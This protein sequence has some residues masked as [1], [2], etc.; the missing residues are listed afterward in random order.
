LRITHLTTYDSTGGAAR[1][2]YRLHSGL[3]IIGKESRVFTLHKELDDATIIRFDPP[4]DFLSRA[5]R[6][7]RRRLLE[8]LG[9]SIASRIDTGS[10]F[11]DNRSQH[12]AAAVLRQLPPTDVLNLHW[13]AGFIDCR[14]FF[15]KIPKEMLV[16]WTLHDMN[17]ITGGCHHAGNC[18]KFQAECGTCPQLGSSVE[19]DISRRIWDSKRQAYAALSKS[20]LTFVT[21]SRW[22]AAKV[23]ESS[24]AAQ[25]GLS[26][27]PYGVDT[28]I[29]R[30]QDRQ[31]ARQALSIAPSAK[32]ILFA[33]YF[34]RDSYK[35]FPVLLEALDRM[36]PA[37]DT[38]AVAVGG[39][40]FD[41]CRPRVPIMPLGLIKDEKR[42]SL[43]YCASD[44]FVLPSLQDNFPNTALEA[45]ACG[46]P[47]VAFETGGIPEIVRNGQTG[48]TVKPGDSEGLARAIEQLLGDSNRRVEMGLECRRVAIEDYSLQVQAY[49][50][51][52]LYS[53]M[54]Q[55]SQS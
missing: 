3:R 13:V 32:V 33:S 55:R 27:F 29:F 50:Y 36:R 44:L 9:R 12:G 49:R 21:P 11:S 23:K 17:A 18:E 31:L 20:R 2:A 42:M 4:R 6:G 30:P 8:R 35:G 10:F 45:L 54:R 52:E 51:A 34:A 15:R 16:V 41:S 28:E 46:I 1:A 22:L 48:I 39:E 25:F 38:L 19:N 47:T 24:L 7:T 40:G 26:V 5:R 37:P 43:A 14:E 53:K